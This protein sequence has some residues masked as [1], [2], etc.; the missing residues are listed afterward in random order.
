MVLVIIKKKKSSDLLWEYLYWNYYKNSWCWYLIWIIWNELS[1][2]KNLQ[3]SL[4]CISHTLDPFEFKAWQKLSQSPVLSWLEIKPLE[5]KI[6]QRWVN[7][8]SWKLI[9][10][11][12]LGFKSELYILSLLGN[13][14]LF[15]PTLKPLHRC[16]KPKQPLSYVVL[17][18]LVVWVVILLVSLVLWFYKTK[19]LAF[20]TISKKKWKVIAFHRMGLKEEDIFAFQRKEN[21]IGLLG[22]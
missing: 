13:P 21:L 16:S 19:F 15:S 6:K 22:I 14:N 8:I 17:V 20:G 10:R 7:L 3:V 11:V 9:L 4:G 1:K 18:M 12:S 5:Q 2:K